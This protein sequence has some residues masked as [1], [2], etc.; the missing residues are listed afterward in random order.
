MVPDR[1]GEGLGKA[2]LEATI[3]AARDHD[4]ERI[5]VATGETDTAAHGLYERLGFRNTESGPDGPA[6]LFYERGL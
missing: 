2:L 4:C 5:D 1:R 3:E 6:M